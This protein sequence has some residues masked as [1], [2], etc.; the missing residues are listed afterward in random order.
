MDVLS[1]MTGIFNSATAGT[2]TQ[3]G[4]D[5][6]QVESYKY[7]TEG[8]DTQG[9][10]AERVNYQQNAGMQQSQANLNQLGAQTAGQLGGFQ[11]L[12][13]QLQ[14]QAGRLGGTAD[15]AF[16]QAQGLMSGESPILQA[17]RQQMLQ[18]VGDLGAQQS[19]QQN[20]MLAQRGLGGGGLRGALA[21][22]QSALG[23][24]ARKGL[25]GIAGQ[26]MQMG[27]GMFGQ[28]LQAQQ[29]QTSALGQSGQALQGGVGALSAAGGM[30]GQAGGLASQADA[31]G[32]QSNLA[33]QAAANQASQFGANW[34]NEANR[35]GAE[36]ANTAASD[37]ATQQYGASQSNAD[38]YN[39]QQQ[40]TLTSQYNQDLANQQRK[41]DF[42]S[43]ALGS[44]ASIK[45]AMLCIP[46]NTKIDT[47]EGNIEIDKLHA[48]DEVI[49]YDGTSTTILQKHEYKENP[50]AKRFLE[51]TMDDNSK[52]NL[53]DMHRIEDVRSKDYSVG[54]SIGSRTI[55][56]IKWYDGVK[57]SYDLLTS[58][59]GY[60]ISGVS[61]N[62]MI[63][64]LVS[65]AQELQEV[66]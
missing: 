43:N 58:N 46:E 33:N 45:V 23:E 38:A 57:T 40:Y 53:C 30:Y 34:A 62:S 65:K 20:R 63:E 29:A 32:L 21:G 16:G 55:T 51:I 60:R 42:F 3:F 39:Q 5:P 59:K 11:N 54:D 8:F 13:G 28:G 37:Y 9:Y 19:Q 36:A 2:N 14:G 47:P 7:E 48:G 50:D 12:A 22:N 56:D 44:A 52:V 31:R 61:V 26:G 15:T 4:Y 41:G 17:Q 24:Q 27:M 10:N 25:L 66:I 18:G 1:P 64:E 6:Q 35:F 49:G